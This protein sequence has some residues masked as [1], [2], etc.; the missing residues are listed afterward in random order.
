MTEKPVISAQFKTPPSTGRSSPATLGRTMNTEIPAAKTSL[1]KSLITPAVIIA[2]LGYFVD[3]FDLLLFSIV[4][5]PSLASLGLDEAAQITEGLFLHNLQ[6]TGMLVGG[7]LWGILADKR[8]RLSVLFGSILLYSIG[9]F[10]NAF[11]HSVEAYAVCR[12][13]AGIGLAGELGAGITLVAETLSKE[14][15]GY[16][17]M[18]VA[19]VG[20]SGAVVGGLI[21]EFFDWRTTYIIGGVL[22]F[23]LLL[24]RINTAESMLFQNAEQAPENR[25]NFLSLFTQWDRFKRLALC[26]LSAVPIWYIIGTLVQLSPELAR[27]VGVTEPITAGR[28]VL[29]CYTGLVFGDFA[30]GALSQWL[31]SRVKVIAAF[32]VGAAL[33]TLYYFLGLQG[34]GQVEFYAVCV[35]LGFFAGY[36]AVFVTVAAEQ[37]GTNLRGTVA[38]SAPNFVRASVVPMSLTFTALKVTQGIPSA[39]GTVGAVVLAIAFLAA[40]RLHETF[41]KDLGYFEID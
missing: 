19:T 40:T 27:E 35:V 10:A 32:I 29:F 34:A 41:G 37:F 15:R 16:G 36:W 20:V 18:I 39:A 12:L 23:A 24:L 6:M 5:K 30:S 25:G 8:G 38:T 21:G 7:I 3:I 26:V 13:I 11:V 33:A 22:G 1:L 4:R 9:N 17:T 28:A 2:S 31:Q 14:H